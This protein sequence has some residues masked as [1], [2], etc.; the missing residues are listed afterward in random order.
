M[1]ITNQNEKWQ[2]V[3]EQGVTVYQAET[4]SEAT[5]YIEWQQ[6]PLDQSGNPAECLTC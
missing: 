3:T 1:E 4:E 6:R 2:V 5:A